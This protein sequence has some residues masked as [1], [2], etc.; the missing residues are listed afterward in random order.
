[1]NKTERAA[2]VDRAELADRIAAL[3]AI[4][5]QW[6]PLDR[7]L[8]IMDT[9][10][11]DRAVPEPDADAGDDLDADMTLAY[12]KGWQDG[13]DAMRKSVDAAVDSASRE[14]ANDDTH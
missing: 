6:S 2:L 5:T 1:M 11:A 4:R 8:A 3:I 12:M 9:V 14:E 13:Q 7:A 10:L